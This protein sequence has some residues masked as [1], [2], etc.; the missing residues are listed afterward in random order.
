MVFVNQ[1]AEGGCVPSASMVKLGFSD[2]NAR[3]AWHVTVSMSIHADEEIAPVDLT[4]AGLGRLQRPSAEDLHAANLL[5]QP[6]DSLGG[7]QAV[8]DKVDVR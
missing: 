6:L 3:A 8:L 7:G 5:T 1:E 2:R 4:Q